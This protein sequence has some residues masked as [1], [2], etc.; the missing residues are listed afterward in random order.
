MKELIRKI[1]KESEEELE[2][3]NLE[4]L[5]KETDP[6]KGAVAPSQ[7]VISDVCEKE[8]F[9]KKQGPITFGQLRKLI[10]TA[11]SKNLA[12]DIGEGF[13]KASIRLIPWF[14]P[15][16][17]IAG[18]IGSSIRAFNKIVRPGLEDTRGY[19]SWWG[20]TMM[21]IMD[22]V[23]GDLPLGDPI[24]KIFFISDGLLHMMDRKVKLKFTRYISELAA[25]K[26]DSEPVPEYFVEN[27][28]RKWINQKF[29]LNP[30][31]Q[32]K[33]IN[34]SKK[35]SLDWIRDVVPDELSISPDV[36]FRSDDEMYYTLDQ[37]GYV[38]EDMDL[39]TMYEL[40]I[41]EGYRWSDKHNGWYHRDE[42][43]DLDNLNES[44]EDGFGWVRDL[45]IES[46]LTPAQIL[47]RYE[48]FPVEVVG[49]YIAGQFKDVEYRG[50]KLYFIAD[51]WCDFV[52]LFDDN[53]G[54]YNRVNRYLAKNVLCDD[55]YWEPYSASDLIGREWKSNV[56][57]LVTENGEA[58]NLVLDHIK[59]HY[60]V[61]EDYNPKQLDIFGEL[62]KER[63][64]YEIG[65]RVLDTQFFNEISQ[66][67]NYLGDLIDDEDIFEELKRELGWA[68]ANS[69]NAAVTNDIYNSTT[70]SIVDLFGS[71]YQWENGDLVFEATDLILSTI[72]EIISDCWSD[73]RRYYDPERH[74]E[75]DQTDEEGFEIFAE[76]CID[77]PFD[78][79]SWFLNVYEER[80][81]DYGGELNPS[82]SDYATSSEMKEYFLEDLQ[83]RI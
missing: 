30:P 46:D 21:M 48:S 57:D 8:K 58:V 77:K 19:K 52:N 28:L 4:E 23:E 72:E 22:T 7:K 1:L 47:L 50:G 24:S 81:R 29:L 38:V 67:L 12:F 42:V 17:A 31:L 32:P 5:P 45:E 59:E 2:N 41:N 43:V 15:Q 82:F 64:I 80:L 83:G 68:Y 62:P 34:E 10:E 27:E 65:G 60:V 54:G 78:N 69:Y 63:E 71:N 25:S 76:E 33:T 44:E 70:D 6:S 11:Q 49:P 66:D 35:D 40:A 3:Q 79:Y 18:F 36:F 16:I 14:F 73:N 26:P 74:K 39:S 61:P 13:Y 51:G 37:L 53:S 56:W 9:C 55:D 75:D 20:K